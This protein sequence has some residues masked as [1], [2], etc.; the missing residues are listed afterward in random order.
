MSR[1][2]DYRRKQEAKH[3]NKRVEIYSLYGNFGRNEVRRED[4][5]NPSDYY[6]D[7]DAERVQYNTT[8]SK[9]QN[10]PTKL[11][12]KI[13]NVSEIKQKRWAKKLKN[14]DVKLNLWDKWTKQ[15]CNRTRRH[16]QKLVDYKLPEKRFL[17]RCQ[18]IYPRDIV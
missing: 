11:K 6:H 13:R 12:N 10:K 15:Y 5:E 2:K 8:G 14:G 7:L 3:Y 9:L 16:F 17:D 1:T 18:V 4:Y